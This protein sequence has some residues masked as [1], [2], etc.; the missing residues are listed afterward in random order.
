MILMSCV[1][2]TDVYN[3]RTCRNQAKLALRPAALQTDTDRQEGEKEEREREKERE[4]ERERERREGTL[5][6][7]TS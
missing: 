7:Y 4:K 3:N 2:S 5:Y 1:H 6:L